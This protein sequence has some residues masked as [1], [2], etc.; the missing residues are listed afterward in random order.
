M[1]TNRLSAKIDLNESTK[2]HLTRSSLTLYSPH[3]QIRVNLR[4]LLLGPGLV[5]GKG[6]PPF[7]L[8]SRHSPCSLQYHPIIHDRKLYVPPVLSFGESHET[9][10]LCG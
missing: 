1:L 10:L 7:K 4:P 2:G 8:C 9:F 6:F 3:H 5:G